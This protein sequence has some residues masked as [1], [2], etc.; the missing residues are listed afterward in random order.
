MGELISVLMCV[1]NTPLKYLVEA[2]DSIIEQSYG[3]MEFI[4]VD[5]ASNDREV[6]DYLDM[7]EH[8]DDRIKLLRNDTN[9]GLTKSLNLGLE[10]C[11]GKYIA[12]MDSDDISMPKRFEKQVLYME[13]H[14]EVSLVGSDVVCFENDSKIVFPLVSNVNVDSETY[15]VRSLMQHSGPPHPTF[16][17]RKSFLD[18]HGIKYRENILKAQDYGIMADILKNGGII[19]RINEPLVRYRVHDGQITTKSELEQKAYQCRVSYDFIGHMFPA[20]NEEERTVLS[21][22]GCNYGSD[23]L[24]ETIRKDD[25]LRK[26]CEF[27]LSGAKQC[28]R[29]LVFVKAIKKLIKY[30]NINKIYD[31][32]IL[33][34]EFRYQWWKKA[35]RT[36]KEKRRLWGMWPYTII[37]YLITRHIR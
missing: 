11:E 22:L 28:D 3:G 32:D 4:I 23:N 18:D 2:I 10:I 33:A 5:D 24:I 7:I 14:P 30:N 15:K 34:R 20:L 17:F 1:Y 29:S 21:V 35:L 8:S 9:R 13:R 27:L 36:S 25:Q 19:S 37:S 12:R 31:S 16:M 26:V 6:V